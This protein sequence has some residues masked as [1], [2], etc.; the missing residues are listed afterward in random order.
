YQR[1]KWNRHACARGVIYG[2]RWFDVVNWIFIS[3]S[4]KSK[5]C[6]ARVNTQHRHLP[7]SVRGEYEWYK[8]QCIAYGNGIHLECYCTGGGGA[9]LSNKYDQRKLCANRFNS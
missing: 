2:G 6:S 3:H 8:T 7:I 4:G 9:G 1:F 5:N